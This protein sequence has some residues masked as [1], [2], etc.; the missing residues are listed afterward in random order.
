MTRRFV[1]LDRDGTINEE[2]G[3]VLHPDELRLLPGVGAA[4]RGLRDLGLGLVVVTNQTPVGRGA[5][6]PEDL[7]AI[8]RRLRAL[9]A[10]DGASLDGFEVCP[11]RRDEG[12]DCRKPATGLV[13]RAAATY[14][15]DPTESWI[16]GDHLGDMG[17]GRAVGA[18]TIL[19]RTGHGEVELAAGAGALAD[20]VVAD[21]PAAAA[22]IREEVLAGAGR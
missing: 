4:L 10:E 11:H 7:H 8:H 3:Y 17:L 2:V 9:L 6:S 5:I 22:V 16:V 15:F 19:V 20:H 1:L 13:E 18:R 21:L 12:C 14:G